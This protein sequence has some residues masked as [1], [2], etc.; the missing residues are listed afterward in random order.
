M[1]AALARASTTTTLTEEAGEYAE[2]VA[3]AGRRVAVVLLVIVEVA[4]VDD[5]DADEQLERDARDEHRQNELVEAM[6]LASDVQ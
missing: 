5:D 2:Q 3:G 4:D 6:S 1:P